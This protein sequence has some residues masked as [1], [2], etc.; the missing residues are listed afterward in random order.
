MCPVFYVVIRDTQH[1]MTGGLLRRDYNLR[2]V[3]LDGGA[4]LPG[5]Q[6]AT[7]SCCLCCF[8]FAFAG[9]VTVKLG[10]LMV[11]CAVQS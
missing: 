5:Y 10:V 4:I 6:L 7:A 3:K 2:P 9:A 8:W 1:R 11:T